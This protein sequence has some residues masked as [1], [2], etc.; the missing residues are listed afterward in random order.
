MTQSEY[1]CPGELPIK[2]GTT[3]RQKLLPSLLHTA[4]RYNFYRSR[5]FCGIFG[6]VFVTG[7]TMFF[8]SPAALHG[9]LWATVTGVVIWA[10]GVAAIVKLIF[11]RPN[12]PRTA[13][14]RAD[15]P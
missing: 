2:E 15:Y 9:A 11:G 14:Q 10:L 7:G 3:M 8:F 1:T 4:P 5:P 13:G 6:V 12:P